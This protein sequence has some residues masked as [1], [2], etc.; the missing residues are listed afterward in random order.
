RQITDNSFNVLN[1][2]FPQSMTLNIVQPLWR[3]LRYDDNRH[4]IQVARK[5]LQLS[6]AQLRQRITDVVTQAVQAYWELTYAYNAVA[7]QT[8]ALGLAEGQYESNK[9][10]ADQGILA[11][12]DVVAAQTQVSTFQQTLLLA[13]QA[14][15]QAENNLKM[16]MLPDRTD[17]MW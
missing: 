13:Q 9:R 10:Q 17:L 11:P 7:V 14:L 8:E 5:N 15:T 1:P 3:G 12:V 4:R 16:L 2:Q 6:E